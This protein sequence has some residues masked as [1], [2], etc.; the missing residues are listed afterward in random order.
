LSEDDKIDAALDEALA[1]LPMPIGARK[2]V[3]T[4][5]TSLMEQWDMNQNTRRDLKERLRRE[6]Q[7]LIAEHDRK[8]LALRQLYEERISEMVSKYKAQLD[9]E[10]RQLVDAYQRKK[11]ELDLLAER[12]EGD[13]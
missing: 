10:Q 6:Q 3:T 8:W 7:N 1:D 9:S 4:G 12:I 2:P 5:S 11:R 13:Q